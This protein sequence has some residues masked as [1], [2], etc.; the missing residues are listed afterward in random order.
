MRA[1]IPHSMILSEGFGRN[2][3][4][5]PLSVVMNGGWGAPCFGTAAAV[6]PGHTWTPMAW[7]LE[8]PG[9]QVAREWEFG[10]QLPVPLSRLRIHVLRG[11]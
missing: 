3:L 10:E 7:D 2:E 5:E 4:F 8:V 9:P 1:R 11:A 6:G